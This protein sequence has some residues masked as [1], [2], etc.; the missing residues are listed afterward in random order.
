MFS[1]STFSSGY[2]LHRVLALLLHA[3]NPLFLFP[4]LFY[5]TFYFCFIF[6]FVPQAIQEQMKLH[7]QEPVSFQDVKVH[8][9]TH[10]L[11]S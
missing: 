11:H 4:H 5:T 2:R 10:R 8:T 6:H 9:C 1:L 7:G 3:R